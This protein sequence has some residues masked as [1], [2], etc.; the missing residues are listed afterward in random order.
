[1]TTPQSYTLT[2]L[3]AVAAIRKMYFETTPKTIQRDLERA[4]EAL[5]H[6]IDAKGLERPTR[7]ALRRRAQRPP[8]AR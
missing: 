8:G 7:S 2:A 4:I 1:M 6:H 5:R 3:T